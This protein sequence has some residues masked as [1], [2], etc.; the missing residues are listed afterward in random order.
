MKNKKIGAALLAG[1]LSIS[2]LTACSSKEPA[3]STP[4]GAGQSEASSSA[5]QSEVSSSNSEQTSANV[6]PF[7]TLGLSMVMSPDLE[8]RMKGD[9]VV[10]IDEKV[11]D[12]GTTLRYGTVNWHRMPSE[13]AETSVASDSLERIGVLGAYQAE[14]VDQLDELTGCD[15][16][17]EVGRSA[18]GAYVYYLSTNSAA[19]KELVEEV[20]K[21]QVTITE[22]EPVDHSADVPSSSFSGTSV[23]DFSTQDVY[24]TAY[25]QDVFKD[26]DLTMVN[27]FT[28]WCSPCVAEMPELE[29]LYQ[30]MKDKGVGVVGVVLDVLNE[31]GEAPQ[32]D[33]ERAQTLVER[34]GVTYPVLLPDSTYFNGRLT[35]IEAFPETFFVDKDGNI[36]GETYS[37]SGDL[38]YWMSIVEKELAAV[39]EGA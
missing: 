38:E 8:Q 39:K 4:D 31:K 24:G 33:L 9:V 20:R 22:M 6:Y 19:D 25:T 16:H 34:T 11:E 29:K 26:Y 13:M 5:G 18:D 17:Q 7:P 1:I 15:N 32:E 36:V 3:S 35:G 21:T 30:Q 2:I 28:T 10:T 27:I 12:Y 37:G 14:L 23:S